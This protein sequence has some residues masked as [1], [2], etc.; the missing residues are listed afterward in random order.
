[1][2][3]IAQF[4][5]D[6]RQQEAERLLVAHLRESEEGSQTHSTGLLTL[7]ELYCDQERYQ[8]A[9]II[10]GGLTSS[11]DLE[12]EVAQRCQRLLTRISENLG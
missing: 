5:S 1:M 9:R 10:S 7:A 11:T 2:D 3:R 6:G 12:G 4:L 8:E